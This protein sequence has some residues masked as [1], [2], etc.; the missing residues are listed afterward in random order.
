[1]MKKLLFLLL[2]YSCKLNAQNI[3]SCAGSNW[4]GPYRQLCAIDGTSPLQIDVCPVNPA[5]SNQSQWQNINS[6][7]SAAAFN[8]L[9][10]GT[11]NSAAMV[12]GGSASL[13]YANTGIINANEC[14]GA[15]CG[16]L[17]GS[18]LTSYALLVG[19]GTVNVKVANAAL[20]SD[21]FGDLT[22]PGNLT[23]LGNIIGSGSIS[24]IQF[25][26]LYSVA[27]T[28][29]PTCNLSNV[30]TIAWVSDGNS[31]TLGTVYTGSGSIKIE[32]ECIYT[33]STYEWL[34]H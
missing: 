12:V 10:S 34:I 24:L 16:T 14:N 1:M 26:N 2:I 33:G 9:T 19:N 28:A 17:L 13:N 31:A 11:N 32:V 29:L 23:V 15:A 5:C 4:S 3:I 7:G 30:A 21:S 25:T 8:S 18:G 20:L 6:S 27:G 22:I